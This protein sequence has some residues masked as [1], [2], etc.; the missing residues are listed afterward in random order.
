MNLQIRLDPRLELLLTAMQL[1]GYEDNMLC[2]GRDDPHSRS[3]RE[4]FGGFCGLEAVKEFARVWEPDY[5]CDILPGYALS[6]T[7]GY[8]LDPE[9]DY[10][11]VREGLKPGASLEDFTRNLRRFA[12]ATG[13]DSQYAQLISELEGYLARLDAIIGS[14]PVLRILEDYLGFTFPRTEILLSTL[15]RPFLSVTLPQTRGET[16]YCLCSLRGLEIAEQNGNLGQI[17]ISAIWHEFSHHVINPLTELL[18]EDPDGIND[19]QVKWYCSLNESIIWAITI[20]L[21]V[22]EEIISAD[23][24]AL[25]V[26][27]AKRNRAPQA[28]LMHD[29]LCDYE[30]SRVR[31]PDLAAYLPVLA[32]AFGPAPR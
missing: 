8:G 3:I 2:V 21:L 29:L 19:A 1:S 32:E 30:Q 16:L 23:S 10:A 5:C 18:F 20:R 27:N 24:V 31:Y 11:L 26:R 14:R 25:M 7:P 22:R 17:L 28:K 9:F 13:F 12:L 4:K 15:T 6:L